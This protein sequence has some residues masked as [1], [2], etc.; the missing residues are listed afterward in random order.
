MMKNWKAAVIIAAVSGLVMA[1]CGQ[2]AARETESEVIILDTEV[3]T[4]EAETTAAPESETAETEAAE[5]ETAEGGTGSGQETE[6]SQGGDSTGS[7]GAEET[8]EDNFAVDSESAAAFA[9]QIKEAVADRDLEKLAD[10]TSFPVYV[11]IVENGTVETREDLL[12]LGADQVFT[13]ELMDSV[14]AA[15]ENSLSPSMAGFVL[16]NE[17]GRPN[18][19]FGVTDGKLGITGINY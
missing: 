4:T 2:Q 18:I 17:S 8:Y 9:S 16:S 1:G 3:K 19:I 14:A 11:G 7:A 12:S 5:R 10:L 6:I 15:D 13:Q